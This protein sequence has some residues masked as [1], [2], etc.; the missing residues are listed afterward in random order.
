MA[1]WAQLG[2]HLGMD[3]KE[4]QLRLQRTP[5]EDLSEDELEAEG[6]RLKAELRALMSPAR[7]KAE[8][9]KLHGELAELAVIANGTLPSSS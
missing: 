7:A 9:Q 1:A 8:M 2:K 4:I 5:V 3:R 6:E